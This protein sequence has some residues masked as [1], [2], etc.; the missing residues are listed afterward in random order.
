[1][2]AKVSQTLRALLEIRDEQRRSRADHERLRGEVVQMRDEVT[3]ELRG[4]SAV[5]VDVRDLLRE[6]LDLRD[7][8]GD[9]E[10]RLTALEK[11][12]G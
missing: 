9:H 8:V 6:R 7:Q 12:T 3:H 11:R 4:V 2:P 1:M 5:L 10:R